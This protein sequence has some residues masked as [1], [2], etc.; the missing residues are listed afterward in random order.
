MEE[1]KIKEAFSKVKQDIL[2]LGNEISQI[3][4]E[5]YEIKHLLEVFRNMLNTSTLRQISSTHPV[6]PTNNP[7]IPY[8]IGGLKDQNLSISTGNEGVP[9][10][11]QTDRQT[12]NQTHF[13]SEIPQKSIEKDIQEASEILASLDALKRE[14]RFKFKRITQQEMLVFSTIYQLEEQDPD[15][16]TYRQIALKLKLSESSIRDYVLRMINKGIPIKKHRINNKK[17]I[18]SISPE[19]KK[20]ATLSTIIKLREL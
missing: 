5:I 10:D 15:N 13:L 7:T 18:L 3:K 6:T 4:S 19:L 20:I 17:L 14:I 1:E 2:V 16:V 8:E 12:D 11:R 9:T